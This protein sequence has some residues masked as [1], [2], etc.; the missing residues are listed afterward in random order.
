M[1]GGCPHRPADWENRAVDLIMS[2]WTQLSSTQ[3]GKYADYLSRLLFARSGMDVYLPEID[4]KGID[5]IIRTKKGAFFEI[6][7]KARRQLNYFYIEKT[8]FPILQTRY[9][10]LVLFLDKDKENPEIYLVPSTVWLTPNA[11]FV[12]RKYEGKKS[13][14][15]WGLQFSKKNM[16]LLKPYWVTSLVQEENNSLRPV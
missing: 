15:E 7:C 10:C 6:Q 5:F 8:K 13:H 9:L 11:L 1:L 2:Y 12:D 14:P 3:L 4:N 16:P